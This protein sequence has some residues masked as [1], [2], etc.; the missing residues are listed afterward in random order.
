MQSFQQVTAPFAGVITTRDIDIGALIAN[1]TAK[2]LFKLAQIDVM[3]V[4][5]NVP[6][7]YSADMHI[8]LAAQLHIA[9][10]PNRVF[11]ER[12]RIRRA[13]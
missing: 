4:Y 11:T 5:V 13:R 2:E 7:G 10:F 12:W 9:E 3:R 8:G 6:E 1:G